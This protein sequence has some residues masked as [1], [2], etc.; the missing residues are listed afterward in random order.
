MASIFP[1]RY[2]INTLAAVRDAFGP[3]GFE[4]YSSP[5][6]AQPRYNFGRS[7]VARFWM[8][9]MAIMPGAMAQSLMV[10]ERKCP[11]PARVGGLFAERM[12]EGAPGEVIG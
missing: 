11:S 7:I 9:W 5:Y 4:H 2:R 8:A 10:F 12:V 1:V 3:H 6:N